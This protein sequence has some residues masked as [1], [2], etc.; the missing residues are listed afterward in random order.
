M[1][2]QVGQHRAQLVHLGAVVE[3]RGRER[4]L[5]E[6]R[7]ALLELDAQLMDPEVC[8]LGA[9]LVLHLGEGAL[10]AVAA[11][12]VRSLG[13]AAQRRVGVVPAQEQR[14]VGRLGLG[15]G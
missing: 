7:R 11:Q 15:L 13:D 3:L 10:L 4:Q 5:A 1:R 9:Q 6:G 14:V 8:L 12:G 2:L